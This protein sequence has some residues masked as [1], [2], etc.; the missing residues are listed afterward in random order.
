MASSPNSR[1][2]TWKFKWP[3]FIVLFSF[4]TKQITKNNISNSFTFNLS[5]L[6]EKYF[7]AEH[8]IGYW[9]RPSAWRKANYLTM[10]LVKQQKGH[11][12]FT[13]LV[14]IEPLVLKSNRGHQSLKEV[15]FVI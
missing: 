4:E 6:L 13:A 10:A 12:Q 7:K 14:C 5:S 3:D 8:A 15:H 9:E 11:L 1:S 2:E